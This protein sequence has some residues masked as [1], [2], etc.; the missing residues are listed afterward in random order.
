MQKLRFRLSIFLFCLWSNT[1]SINLG[2]TIPT[3]HEIGAE[4]ATIPVGCF[5]NNKGFVFLQFVQ[6][7]LCSL[8]LKPFGVSGLWGCW[9]PFGWVLNSH[10]YLNFNK[11]F[12]LWLVSKIRKLYFK[13]TNIF[14]KC[15]NIFSVF[16]AK[17]LIFFLVAAVKSVNHSAFFSYFTS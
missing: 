5:S 11:K 16:F 1:R 15:M 10:I 6:E 8:D 9:G 13:F 2:S 4:W 12:C 7:M 3:I 17:M 14:L